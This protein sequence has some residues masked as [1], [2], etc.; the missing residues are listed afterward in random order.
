MMM[1]LITWQ[2]IMMRDRSNDELLANEILKE[3]EKK[4]RVEKLHHGEVR[5]ENFSILFNKFIYI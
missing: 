5:R 1:G 4:K 3:I 2:L